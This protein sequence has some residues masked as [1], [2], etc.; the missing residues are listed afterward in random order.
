MS[1]RIN[2]A[3]S[4]PQGYKAMSALEQY[5]QASDVSKTHL[6]LIKIRAS[7]INGCAFCLDMHTKDALKKGETNQRIFLLNAWK[8]TTLFT[9][10]ERV[11]LSMTEE[12]TLIHEHGLSEA[13]YLKAV[14]LLGEQYVAQV[15]MAIVTING[16]NRI[17]V[18]MQY[19]IPE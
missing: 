9:E 1:E 14:E 12:V 2:I 11:I 4:E 19:Q 5:I 17:A 13:T 7:Q 10:E 16:W 8:E 3:K 6:E 18:S 15:L